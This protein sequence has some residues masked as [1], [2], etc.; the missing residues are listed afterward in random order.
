LLISIQGVLPNK[1][2]EV[3]IKFKTNQLGKFGDSF[4]MVISEMELTV[5]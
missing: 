3:S 5:V 4:Q 1:P 2:F